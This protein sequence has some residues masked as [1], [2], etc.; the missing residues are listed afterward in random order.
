[1]KKPGFSP[2]DMKIYSENRQKPG[3]SECIFTVKKQNK[4]SEIIFCL[5]NYLSSGH[6]LS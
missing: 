4:L 6:L 5:L 2:P 1:M 3:F